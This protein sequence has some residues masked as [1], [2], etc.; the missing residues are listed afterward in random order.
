MYISLSDTPT[1]K[2]LLFLR[3]IN[4]LALRVH[5]KNYSPFGCYRQLVASHTVLLD[6]DARDINTITRL[7]FCVGP[8]ADAE[9]IKSWMTLR[10]V[11]VWRVGERMS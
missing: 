8:D 2:R 3:V 6:L 1:L 10:P 7:I 11:H 4:A 9:V 5:Y